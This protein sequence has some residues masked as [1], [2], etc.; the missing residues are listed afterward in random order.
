VE[1][2]SPGLSWGW[3][4]PRRKRRTTTLRGIK[5]LASD[6]QDGVSAW[7]LRTVTGEDRSRYRSEGW[8]PDETL[9]QRLAARLAEHR[10]TPFVIH[11]K[12]RP[13]RGTFG[14]VLELAAS[15]AAGLQDRGVVAGD[16]VSFQTPNW[17]EG[18]ATFYGA[19]MLGAIVA[20][21]V[22]IYGRHELSY[23]LRQC[24]PKVHVTAERFGA[25]DYLANLASLSDLPPIDVAVVGV[26]APKE[27]LRFDELISSA[28]IDAPVTADPSAPA[29]VGWTSGTTAN[30]KGVVHSHQTVLAEVKQLGERTP[31]GDRPSVLANPI[32]HAIGMLGALLIPID[33]GRP[34]HLL[35]QWDPAV[36]LQL[37]KDENL[38]SGGGAPYFL[39]SLL[40]H[41]DF[42]EEHL[43]RIAYQG[44]GGAPVP[45]AVTERATALGITV[46]R[47]YGSTEH[48][49]I[50]GC[51]YSD[52]LD[53]RLNT[54]GI[55]LPGNEIRL[56]DAD[57]KPVDPGVPGEILSRG[58]ELFIGY[59][60]PALT[61]KVFDDEGWYHT[62][63]IAVM[64]EDGYICITDRIS[65]V[66]IRGGENISAAEVEELLLTLPGVAEVAVVAAPDPRMGEH[67]AA[68][69]R[70]LPGRQVPALTEMQGHLKQAGLARQKWPEELIE[71]REF[72]R[73]A[74][75]KI[76]KFRL[77]EQLRNPGT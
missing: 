62:G 5:H 53:K 30:P 50:T 54:D 52:P 16:V 12:T 37:M 24:R 11:S 2:L 48:P 36:V 51:M 14:D 69:V 1:C 43:S 19:A 23:I 41:P 3:R 55:P 25:Q 17:V 44:M 31:P 40:D 59:T 77:R 4:R 15:V 26:T 45:R 76:Q 49:S 9:G 72:P 58:P 73:T 38:S 35:D 46:F 57:G 56:V 70:M 75:G 42:T 22:H 7:G 61:A 74:S 32:S 39:T 20:P 65:D 21:V 66:I 10:D 8:W 47:A 68:V 13:W 34:V 28:P 60:D 63:D 29:L 64:D 67:A 27:M 6:G 71:A 33:R 18:A